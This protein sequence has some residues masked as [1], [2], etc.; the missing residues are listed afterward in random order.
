MERYRSHKFRDDASIHK[1]EVKYELFK[2]LDQNAEVGPAY[3]G[4]D[5]T[6]M[7]NPG[8]VII[9]MPFAYSLKD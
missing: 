7:T 3:Y 4:F 5:E 9:L 8:R 2:Y 1:F 6:D